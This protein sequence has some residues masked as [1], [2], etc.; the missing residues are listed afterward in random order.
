MEGNITSLN[1]AG[2]IQSPRGA[3]KDGAFF[4][5]RFTNVD[6][7]PTPKPKKIRKGGSLSARQSPFHPY[8]F[9]LGY[10]FSID[11][12]YVFPDVYPAASSPSCP[13]YCLGLCDA[14]G[15]RR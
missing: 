7:G 9:G 11:S 1:M 2:G 12:C 3:M 5:Y 14:M 10:M 13:S 8:F 4:L 15:Q 6:K